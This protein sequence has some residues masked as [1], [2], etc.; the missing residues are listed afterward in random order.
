MSSSRLDSQR[1]LLNRRS[2]LGAGTLAAAGLFLD[3]SRMTALAR[4]AGGADSTGA[5]VQTAAGKVRGMLRERVQEFKGVPYGASTAGPQRFLP[6]LKPKSWTGV[7]D[8]FELGLRA[9]QM[10]GGVVA[11][12]AAFNRAEPMGEDCLCLNV[13]TPGV[14][15]GAKRPVMVWLHGGGYTAG[16]A[17]GTLYDGHELA[18]KHNVVVVGVNHR[19]NVFGFLYLAGLGG[20]KYA[21]AHNA[22]MLDIVAAL[23]WVRDNITAFGGD[24]GNVTI[25]GQSGGGGKVSRLLAMPPAKG[26]F[27]RAIAESGSAVKGVSRS[28][29]TKSAESFMMKLGLKPDQIDELQKLPM[30]KLLAAMGGRGGAGLRLG[31]VVDGHSLP[32]DPFDPVAPAISADIPLLIGTNETEVTFTPNLK[33]DPID[34]DGLRKRVKDALH[35]EDA[36]ADRVIAV[37]RKN[38]PKASDL[39]LAF[40]IET[41]V[42]NFRIGVDTEAERKSAL[43]KAPVY[44]YRFT[45]YS[46]VRGGA[47]RS[48]HTMEIPFVFDNVD[49]A[50]VEVGDGPE[51]YALAD[52][53]SDAWVAFARTGNPNHSGLPNWRPFDANQRA[54]M[55]F[56]TEC[57]LVND[58][59]REER[60]TLQALRRP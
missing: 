10:D 22:G 43:G 14:G 21:N 9:P 38:R 5:T 50:K 54:T 42:S 15:D 44:V 28:D 48:M 29:A 51:R 16:S 18:R 57:K 59:Y 2:F 41:D 6:P 23:E 53:M 3:S 26:L 56:N 31:P 1:N 24:P 46:P 20:E 4:A 11:E 47:L 49:A 58:P 34:G 12:W 7:R 25:F 39:D 45:W 37:Y 13:W 33:N 60:L 55:I 8:A 27:H 35:V 36:Q 32:T 30:E 19:L 40:I 17:G 52:K